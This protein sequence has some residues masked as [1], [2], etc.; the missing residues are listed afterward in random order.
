MLRNIDGQR[1]ANSGPD[2]SD[3]R[4]QMDEMSGRLSLAMSTTWPEPVVDSCPFSM[5]FPRSPFFWRVA[6]TSQYW[7]RGNRH[8]DTAHGRL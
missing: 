3:V 8:A 2:Q 6:E 5:W 7:G 4:I 1:P